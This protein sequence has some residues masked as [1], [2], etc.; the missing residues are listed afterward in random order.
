MERVKLVKFLKIILNSHNPFNGQSIDFFKKQSS[1]S[2]HPNRVKSLTR[3]GMNKRLITS[4]HEDKSKSRFLNVSFMTNI[5]KKYDSIYQRTV[6][7]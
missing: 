4:I 6:Y 7:I 2:K 1:T 3:P 5:F